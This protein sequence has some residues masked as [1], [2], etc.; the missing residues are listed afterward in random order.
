MLT[1][2][3][4]KI[5]EW[6]ENNKVLSSNQLAILMGYKDTAR[7]RQHVA[8][9]R[10]AFFDE[11][12]DMLVCYKKDKGYFLSNNLEDARYLIERNEKQAKTMLYNNS[13]LRKKMQVEDNLQIDI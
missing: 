3:Q 6:L 11:K 4:L 10:Q 7:V 2:E 12:V 5:Y 13:I 1:S 9:L 8:D